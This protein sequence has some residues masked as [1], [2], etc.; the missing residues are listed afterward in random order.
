MFSAVGGTFKLASVVLTAERCG[1]VLRT[2]LLLTSLAIAACGG[3]LSRTSNSVQVVSVG[4]GETVE[5]AKR[6]A[7]R[8]AVQNVFGTLLV[9]QRLVVDDVLME[10]D[11]SYSSGVI[12]D[13][14]VLSG[15]VREAATGL[16]KITASVA[17]SDARF[18]HRLE[19]LAEAR[20][21]DFSG[22]R[23][24]NSISSAERRAEIQANSFRD[25]REQAKDILV[26]LGRQFPVVDVDVGKVSVI[27]RGVG[28]SPEVSVG[29]ELKINQEYLG[30]F[31]G[32]L[33]RFLDAS[34]QSWASEPTGAVSV[35]SLKWSV[36]RPINRVSVPAVLVGHI[37][38][39]IRTHGVCLDFYDRGGYGIYSRWYGKWHELPLVDSSVQGVL[40]RFFHRVRQ[41]TIALLTKGRK[42]RR[43]ELRETTVVATHFSWRMHRV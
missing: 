32:A 18:R 41:A 11:F 5:K 17:V 20:A 29:V 22:G 1:L 6:D 26:H 21:S 39:V 13:Y 34:G 7:L 12:L 27:E 38:S 43:M 33:V 35:R 15:P 16:L 23:I 30:A 4:V 8:N 3:S 2:F 9:T 42:G 14:R 40:Q 19:L 36:C 10:E 24:A 28:F 25:R 31:C 37:A